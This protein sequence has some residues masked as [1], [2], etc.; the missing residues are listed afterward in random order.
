MANFQLVPEQIAAYERD[1][2]LIVPNF[3]SEAE[4]KKLYGIAIGDD[5]MN[6]H[7]FDLNDQTGKKRPG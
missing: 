7:A 4:S 2:Y 1:G 5:A 3:L 6:K